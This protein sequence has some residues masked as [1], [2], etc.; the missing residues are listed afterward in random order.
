MKFLYILAKILY[1]PEIYL[2][3]KLQSFHASKEWVILDK[4]TKNYLKYSNKLQ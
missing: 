3:F 4:I 2:N 1:F